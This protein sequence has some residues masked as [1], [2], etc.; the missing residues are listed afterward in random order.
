MKKILL[1]TVIAAMAAFADG[2]HSGFYLAGGLGIGPGSASWEPDKGSSLETSGALTSEV[3]LRIGGAVG[4]NFAIHGTFIYTNLSNYDYEMDGAK[5][6]TNDAVTCMMLGIG[7]TYY[8]MPVNI[9]LSGSIGLTAMDLSGDTDDD[10]TSDFESDSNAG[11]GLQLA[12]GK[13]WMVTDNI[14][15][16]VALSATYLGA[17][18]DAAA[19]GDLYYDNVNL[20][21]EFSVTYN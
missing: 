11:L 6:S 1:F 9:F 10:G 18:W 19:G 12:L 15:L 20:A 13:E 3:D 4:S 17:T 5:A 21:V 8:F 2:D 14:G 16:G 7:G